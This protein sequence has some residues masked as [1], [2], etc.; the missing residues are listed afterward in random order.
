MQSFHQQIDL[1]CSGRF[2]QVTQE[3]LKDEEEGGN[4]DCMVG[5]EVIRPGVIKSSL[6]QCLLMSVSVTANSH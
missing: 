1:K 2:D 6:M 4:R 5:S 3:M